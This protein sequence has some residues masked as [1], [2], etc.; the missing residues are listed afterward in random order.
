M[1]DLNFSMGCDPEFFLTDEK[2]NHISAHNIVPG[3]KDE[4]FKLEKG[5]L[6]ADG[7]AV[8]FNTDPAYSA[9]EFAENIQCV[10]DQVREIVPKELNFNFSPAIEYEQSYFDAL[11]EYCKVLGCDPDMSAFTLKFN[12]PPQPEGTMRTAGGHLHV[13]W[14]TEPW[15]VEDEFHRFNAQQVVYWMDKCLHTM[16]S[17]HEPANVRRKMYGGAGAMR[18]KP[19]GVEYRSPS[20]FWLQHPKLW[21]FIFDFTRAGFDFMSQGINPCH[22]YV[23]QGLYWASDPLTLEVKQLSLDNMHRYNGIPQ[24]TYPILEEA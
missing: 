4:P 12:N 9:E 24:L 20:N 11:P 15:D 5:A 23:R 8:E 6:Q 17:T 2:G 21:P 14:G 3:T 19:Y 16:I 10:L 22:S 13:G 18:I 7:T 1:D